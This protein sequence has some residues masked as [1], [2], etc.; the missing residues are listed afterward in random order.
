MRLMVTGQA[1]CGSRRVPRLPHVLALSH[2]FLL[3]PLAFTQ[4][5][6]ER[7]GLPD[8]LCNYLSYSTRLTQL[9]KWQLLFP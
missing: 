9:C 7:Y 5:L 4:G 1:R 6:W 3:V 2:W 8:L